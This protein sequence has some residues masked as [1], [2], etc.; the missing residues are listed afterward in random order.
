MSD[1]FTTA[2]GPSPFRRLIKYAFFGIAAL[3][4]LGLLV[5]GFENWRGRRA[6]EKFRAEWEAKGEQ[7]DIAAFIPK[8]VPPEENFATTPLLAPLLDY[9]PA[10]PGKWRDPAGRDRANAVSGALGNAPG[11]KVPP[12]GNW[13]TGTFV[14]LQQWQEYFVG[15]TNYPA[16]TNSGNPA[17][18]VLAALR[19]FDAELEELTQASARPHSVFPVRYEE[20]MNALLPHL[21]TLKG[22]SQLIRLR[23]LARLQAGRKPEALQDA[24][25]SLHLAESI[26]SEAFLIS[27]LVRIAMLQIAMQPI[28]EG[29]ARHEWTEE[30][31]ATLQSALAS[32]RLL[33]DYGRTMRGE[34][35]FSN[36]VLDQLRTGW[37]RLCDVTGDGDS[38]AQVGA[39]RFLPSGWFYQ[40]QLTINRLHQERMLPLVNAGQHRV[41]VQQTRDAEDVP[42]LKKFNLYNV[43]ARLLL[44][45]VAR[46]AAKFANGQTTL[47]LATV[48][49]AL[50]R[51]RLAHGQYPEQL[52]L[53]VPRFIAKIPSDVIN[54]ELLKY[55]REPDGTFV[56][57]SVGW[58]EADDGGEVGLT[59]AGTGPDPNQGDWVWRHPK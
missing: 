51:H 41:F 43:F 29:C 27:Q 15:H 25:L 3:I 4:L 45:A 40:N 13:Q 56:L 47:D 30:Q 38:A 11:E 37:L 58:N 49:C 6:W 35:A 28:W 36:A 19:K 33:E 14:D 17:R 44:P 46:T 48:A 20:H 54:G 10:I 31:L 50:E 18:D 22:I 9:D 21:A 32:I 23:A 26:G 52:D 42:E 1:T 57:Y 2:A 55:R 39:A 5:A 24:R 59:R 12:A 8:P 16:V 7:F 34:R 53:L